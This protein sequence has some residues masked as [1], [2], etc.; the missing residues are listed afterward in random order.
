MLDI[1]KVIIFK[2]DNNI[3]KRRLLESIIIRQ[4]DFSKFN[5]LFW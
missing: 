1:W 3:V 5:Q 4:I 2:N